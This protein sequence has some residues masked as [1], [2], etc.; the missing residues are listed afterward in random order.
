MGSRRAPATVEAK[1]AWLAF[2][3]RHAKLLTEA[4]LPELIT[5]SQDHWDDFLM[6]GYLDHH[7]DPSGFTVNCLSVNQ[8]GAL[9]QLVGRYVAE[10]GAD[11]LPLALEDDNADPR[12][13]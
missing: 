13:T 11:Y 10:L 8:R 12:A 7:A 9:K 4:A 3:G 6:H 2:I 1:R 5:E